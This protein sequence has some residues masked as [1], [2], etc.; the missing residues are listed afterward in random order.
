MKKQKID[1][2]KSLLNKGEH[3]SKHP[4]LYF[5]QGGKYFYKGKEITKEQYDQQRAEYESNNILT[6]S[7]IEPDEL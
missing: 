3:D 2:V 1:K 7:F 6:L 4:A 5:I